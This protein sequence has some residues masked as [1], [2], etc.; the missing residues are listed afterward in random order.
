MNI[1]LTSDIEEIFKTL[2]SFGVIFAL[3]QCFFG[4]RLM[5]LWITVIGF[6]LGFTVSF[7]AAVI[8]TSDDLTMPLV[9]GVIVGLL[10]GLIAFRLYLTGVFLV[11]GINAFIAVQAIP[12]PQEEGWGLILLLGGIAAF[13]LVGLISLKLARMWMISVTAITGAANA[14]N[15]LRPS[16]DALAENDALFLAAAG[17]LA[18]LGILVQRAMM[19]RADA[20]KAAKAE[21]KAA[22]G[23]ES[24]EHAAAPAP[25]PASPAP[26]ADGTPLQAD[27]ENAHRASEDLDSAM[28]SLETSGKEH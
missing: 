6:L 22:D 10:S 1:L 21:R 7:V 18:I 20:K 3:L 8:F 11:C 5:K 13:F 24:K 25:E 12:V 9:L 16:V 19:K 27:P 28:E 2:L 15:A 26:S 14:V 17:V 4:Y 23:K